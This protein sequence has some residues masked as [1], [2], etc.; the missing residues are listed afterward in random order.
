MKWL[1]SAGKWRVF[2]GCGFAHTHSPLTFHGDS[3]RWRVSTEHKSKCGEKG[4]REGENGKH[5]SFPILFLLFWTPAL[6]MIFR[7]LWLYLPSWLFSCSTLLWNLSWL[8][9]RSMDPAGLVGWI[10]WGRGSLWSH[11]QVWKV[12]AISMIFQVGPFW[13]CFLVTVIKGVFILWLHSIIMTC[14]SGW[15]QQYNSWKWK[16]VKKV[17][18]DLVFK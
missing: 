8:C 11:D 16:C 13:T 4:K 15:P 7:V 5:F 12:W 17:L 14:F 2:C 6:A 1:L 18:V 9:H 3:F 10:P